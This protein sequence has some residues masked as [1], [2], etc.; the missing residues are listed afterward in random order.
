[1]F[2]FNSILNGKTILLTGGTG[3]FGRAFCRIVLDKFSPKRIIVLSRDELKQ[4]EMRNDFGADSRLAFFLGDIR[5]KARLYRAL[6]ANVDIVI[7]AAALKQVPALE[8]NPF[9]AVLTNIIGAQNLIEAAIDC[10]VTK[11][12]AVSTDK[13]SN[14]INLYGATKLCMEKLFVAGN[15]YVGM[16][17]TRFACVRYGNVVGSRGSVVPLFKEQV[18]T[19][20]LSITDAEM[21]RFWITLDQGVKLVLEALL[22]MSGGEVF[23]PKIPSMKVF[24]LAKLIGPDCEINVTGIRPGE[25]L[26][27]IL[28]S[29]DEARNTIE[30]DDKYIILRAGEPL[31]SYPFE[32]KRLPKN[33]Q[34][35]SNTNTQWLDEA[36]LRAMIG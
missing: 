31:A 9:E 10:A 7:H 34:Y 15:S 20:R 3:S 33:F 5:D 22:H 1:M 4:H 14:P 32:Y 6:K 26:H 16:G 17:N 27:E 28:V 11:V 13:A 12:I 21:T 29:A 25:K 8:Y 2:M 23:I 19:G 35:A 18:K 24:D 36:G 30:T